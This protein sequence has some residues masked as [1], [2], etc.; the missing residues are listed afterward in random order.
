MK[1]LLPIRRA[2]FFAAAL[3]AMLT[4]EKALAFR[5]PADAEALPDYD[6]RNEAAA[7]AARRAQPVPKA[8]LDAELVLRNR[9]P[10]VQIERHAIHG[11]PKWITAREGFL[12]DAGGQGKSMAG[13]VPK[14][15]LA[16][17]DSHRVIKAFV[18]EHAGLFGH[19]ATALDGARTDCARWF[20]NR[21]T[22]AFASS[23]PCSLPTSRR[24]RSW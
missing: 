22:K 3:G 4:T 13:A 21:S 6:R 24:T 19:D 15:A 10:D 7:A 14:R 1:T 17:N 18:D 12:T 20:G 2:L 11:S 9:V 8:R 16:P 23:T 5:A